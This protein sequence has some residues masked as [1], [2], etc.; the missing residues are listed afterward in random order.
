MTKSERDWSA[1]VTQTFAILRREER[2][3]LIANL[4]YLK[5]QR[6]WEK[7][8]GEPEPS[9]EDRP[10]V[11]CSTNHEIV[12]PPPYLLKVYIKP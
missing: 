6:T 1:T 11:P 7:A 2:Q 3:L 5:E 4:S 10:N 8:G 9:G 12:C